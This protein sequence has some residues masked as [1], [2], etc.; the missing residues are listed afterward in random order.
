MCQYPEG[1][2]YSGCEYRNIR[3]SDGDMVFVMIYSTAV[4]AV[5]LSMLTEF[6]ESLEAQQRK[7]EA[8]AQRVLLEAFFEGAKIEEAKA[9]AV[10]ISMYVTTHVGVC[11]LVVSYLAASTCGQTAFLCRCIQSVMHVVSQLLANAC[12]SCFG[13]T[14]SLTD[15]KKAYR[16]C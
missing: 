11:T 2:S 4:V 3:D 10:M 1:F 5:A 16:Y 8:K 9:K 6:M 13:C 14:H 15:R 12:C 7:R